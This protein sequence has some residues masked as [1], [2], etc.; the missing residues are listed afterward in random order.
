MERRFKPL[1]D[2]GITVWVSLA[3]GIAGIVVTVLGIFEWNKRG[4]E[5]ETRAAV[6]QQKAEQDVQAALIAENA[7]LRA[8]L[9][10]M[11]H[12]ER[13]EAMHHA[14]KEAEAAE[15]RS[16]MIQG[17]ATKCI[18]DRLFQKAGNEWREVARC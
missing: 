12:T 1:R 2:R 15:Q 3:L 8:L 17:Q 14:R 9:S 7:R 18:G 4:I 11:Q 16:R 6:A 5:R 13:L 10:E